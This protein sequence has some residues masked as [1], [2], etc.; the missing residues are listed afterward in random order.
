MIYFKRI[1]K[2][3]N[4]SYG[5]LDLFDVCLKQF[6]SVNIANNV[7]LDKKVVSGGSTTLYIGEY[8]EVKDGVVTKYIFGGNLRLAV[9][10]GAN[11]YYYHKDHLGSTGAT[12]DVNGNQVEGADYLPFGSMREHAGSNVS[13]Y[14]FTDQELDNE[15]NL[16]NYDARLYDP[17]LGMFVTPDSIVPNMFDPQ[18]LNRYSY[19]R[20]NPLIYVDPSG[21]SFGPSRPGEKEDSINGKG[22]VRDGSWT[23]LSDWADKWKE[24]VAEKVIEIISKT[25]IGRKA[26][27]ATGFTLQIDSKKGGYVE[28]NIAHLEAEINKPIADYV[29]SFAH[30]LGHAYGEKIGKV[31]R[32]IARLSGSKELCISKE[33][34]GEVF[35]DDFRHTVYSELNNKDLMSKPFEQDKWESASPS[36][37]YQMILDRFLNPDIYRPSTDPGWSY[38]DYYGYYSWDKYWQQKFNL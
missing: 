16:Y 29:N 23:D 25:Y 30:E 5:P 8:Y 22:P 26:L 19:C 38:G 3:V 21:H 13:D 18:D 17:V 12:T 15:T 14:K 6:Y 31:E 35:A 7:P 28:N 11:T 10:K 32:C 1:K 27:K 20:N 4:S 34:A 2:E 37:R 33:L 9:V 36:Q 24:H